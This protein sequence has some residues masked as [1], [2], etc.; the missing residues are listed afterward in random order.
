MID[1]RRR[2]KWRSARTS[3]GHLRMPAPYQY[4]DALESTGERERSRDGSCSPY[5]DGTWSMGP[6]TTVCRCA[7]ARAAA[8]N[9]VGRDRPTWL[10]CRCAKLGPVAASIESIF[11]I[12]SHGDFRRP[13]VAS[14]CHRQLDA[15]N[16]TYVWSHG[17]PF[18]ARD[19]TAVAIL[20]EFTR[21][22]VLRTCVRE[23]MCAVERVSP[24]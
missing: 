21:T 1:T 2:R 13:P 9:G 11:F 20:S 17:F 22:C 6:E 4:G 18:E 5:R 23:C 19:G 16:G 15:D 12:V 3:A 14:R 24:D 7:A 10:S 8:G